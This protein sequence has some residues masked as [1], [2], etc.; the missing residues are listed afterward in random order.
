MQG[1]KQTCHGDEA[2]DKAEVRQVIRVDGGSRID[3]Q[4]VVTLAG[5][6][7]QTVHGVQ[8]LVREKEKP[9]PN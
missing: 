3:L 6:L 1:L 7:K 2:A 8:D 5:I 9:L 4:T